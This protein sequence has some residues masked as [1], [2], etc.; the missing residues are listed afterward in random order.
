MTTQKGNNLWQFSTKPLDYDRCHNIMEIKDCANW[1][2]FRD[3]EIKQTWT[4][5]TIVH[6]GMKGKFEGQVGLS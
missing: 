4:C 6:V 3:S 2:G 5:Y 1:C